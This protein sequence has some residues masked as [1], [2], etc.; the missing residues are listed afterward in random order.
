MEWPI[1]PKARVVILSGQELGPTHA[2]LRSTTAIMITS[3]DL[4]VQGSGIPNQFLGVLTHTM[5][6]D[7]SSA[8]VPTWRAKLTRIRA[9]GSDPSK[10]LQQW[11]MFS[12]T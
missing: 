1:Q 2:S 9:R 10:S 3:S 12:V 5:P 6:G 4:P 7:P 11:K 8:R